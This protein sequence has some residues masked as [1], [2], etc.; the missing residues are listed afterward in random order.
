MPTDGLPQ[1]LDRGLLEVAAL[2]ARQQREKAE[3]HRLLRAANLQPTRPDEETLKQLDSSVKRNTGFIKKLR[4]LSEENFKPLL[5]ELAKLNQT[6]YVAEV[7]SAIA[8]AP[9]RGRDIDGAIQ[10]CSLLHQ[11]YSDFGEHLVAAL[12]KS[13]TGRDEAKDA[14]QYKRTRLKILADLLVTGIY[15]DYSILIDTLRHVAAVNFKADWAGSQ[16]SMLLLSSF[17]RHVSDELLGITS[18]GLRPFLA[19]A[20][21]VSLQAKQPDDSLAQLV[22]DSKAL[23]TELH[24][25]PPVPHAV[26]QQLIKIL[27]DAYASASAAFEGYKQTLI[28]REETYLRIINSRGDLSEHHVTTQEAERSTAEAMQKNIASLADALGKPVPILPPAVIQQTATAS[29]VDILT[30]KEEDAALSG[31]FEDEESRL[32]YESLPDLRAVVPGVLLGNQNVSESKPDEDTSTEMA[33]TE[34]S[35]SPHASQ[36]D[37]PDDVL[38]PQPSA[39]DMEESGEAEPEPEANTPAERQAGQRMLELIKRLSQTRSAKACDDWCLAFCDINSKAS[40][41]RLVRELT[42]VSPMK[43]ALLPFYAR[44][45]ATLSQIFTSIRDG[46]QAGLERSFRYYKARK[47]SDLRNVERRAVNARYLSELVK[48]RSMPFG[49]F[50]VLLKS[51]L[52]DF[53]QSNVETAATLVEAAGRFLYS[54]PETRVRMSNMLEVMQRLKI[55]KNLNIRQAMLVENAYYICR[56]P[57]RPTIEKRERT[58]LQQYM[59]HL[60]HDQLTQDDTKQI[61]RKLRR[62][63]WAEN[64]PYLI[65]CLLSASTGRYSLAPVLASLTA[66]LSRY[67]PSLR[68]GVIDSLLE[69]VRSGMEEPHLGTYQRRMGHIVLLGEMYNYKLVDS[70]IIFDTLHLFLWYGN[71]NAEEAAVLDPPSDFF[72]TRL[73]CGLLRTC[74]MFFSR[75]SAASRLD[76]FLIFFQRYLLSKAPAP[77]EVTFEVQDLFTLLRPEMQRLLTLEEACVAAAALEAQLEGGLE[78]IEEVPSDE[79]DGETGSESGHSGRGNGLSQQAGSQS[80]GADLMRHELDD[81]TVRLLH[82]VNAGEVEVD[83]EFEREF[84]SL[85]L[86]TGPAIQPSALQDEPEETERRMPAPAVAF[87]MLTK[88]AGR[89]DRSRAVQVPANAAI[90]QTLRAR[91]SAEADER[92]QIKRLTLAA[93]QRAQL[94]NGIKPSGPQLTRIQQPVVQPEQSDQLNDLMRPS[95]QRASLNT[96]LGFVFYSIILKPNITWQVGRVDEG[97]PFMSHGLADDRLDRL[98]QLNQADVRPLPA[99]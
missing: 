2:Q 16:S 60:V 58:P 72:R 89:D 43:M 8:D 12:T 30:G 65:R 90:V 71:D 98:L 1:E 40:R 35:P 11:R 76:R 85:V 7:V 37:A 79:E 26:Q 46:V 38:E 4:Q 62:L 70:R 91:A 28:R 29:S 96:S 55:A 68:T 44:I 33:D 27:L 81:D 41:N 31:P 77:L 95:R 57:D 49:S 17:A 15:R 74:G 78:A 93:D 32:F 59:R 3:Q 97:G 5:D 64:E 47:D 52:D 13:I 19:D 9:L 51:L 45:T 53:A 63:P 92:A 54:L 24:H 84:A 25:H 99:P 10:I 42:D 50:F 23:S 36:E 20:Q 61:L 39:A 88:K 86:S 56:P 34:E 66:G 69:E 48:F 18:K 73:V 22:A 6:R 82:P 75:G 80:G 94:E 83:D 14:L 21:P 87:R 67:H